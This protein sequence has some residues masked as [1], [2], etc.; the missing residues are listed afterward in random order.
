M[1]G[2]AHADEY[3]ER[4]NRKGREGRKGT[5]VYEEEIG[6]LVVDSAIKVH[7]A[8]GPG[9]LESAYRAC[10]AHE[11]EMRGLDVSQEKPLPIR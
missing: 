9:L 8:L 1:D 11:L 4:L 3:A 7:S 2:H 10:L 5:P 6:A